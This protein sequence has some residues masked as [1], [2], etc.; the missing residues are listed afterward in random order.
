[1]RLILIVFTLQFA[2]L[3]TILNV[4]VIDAVQQC[5]GFVEL[6]E[7]SI[8]QVTLAGTHNSAAGFDGHLNFHSVLGRVKAVSC[9]Y[10]NQ[11]DNIYN[12]LEL[13]KSY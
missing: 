8:E 5:N 1:M 12:Q 11:M 10:R 9:W 2:A 3:A 13:G 6:C 4:G 7:L